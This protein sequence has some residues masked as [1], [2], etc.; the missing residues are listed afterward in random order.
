[1]CVTHTHIHTGQMKIELK[2]G[3]DFMDADDA[4]LDGTSG[5]QLIHL[6]TAR[7]KSNEEKN[8]PSN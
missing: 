8:F 7:R 4:E 6:W 5:Y 2:Y 1:M 3:V